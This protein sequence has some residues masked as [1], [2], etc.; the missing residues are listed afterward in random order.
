[1]GDVSRE[2]DQTVRITPLIVV[3]NHY[4]YQ[5]AIDNLGQLQIDD[6]RVAIAD[7]VATD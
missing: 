4:L 5:I 3:P 6:A 1:M 2:F 7:V